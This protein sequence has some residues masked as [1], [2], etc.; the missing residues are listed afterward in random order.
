MSRVKKT[1][2]IVGGVAA[3][4]VFFTGAK[5]GL[6]LK[7][8][9]DAVGIP[10]YCY[11]ETRNARMGQVFTK[12]QCDMIF[13]ARLDEF[14]EGIERCAPSIKQA[15]PKR[16]VAHLSLAYNIGTGAYCK[17]S[18][19]RLQNAGH[20]IAA[21]DMFLKWNR[22]G[23]MVLRGLTRRRIEERDWCRSGA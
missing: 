14:G 23:G 9:R 13:I 15:P 7:T 4:A 18:V 3:L 8:Y 20:D 10:T 12:P 6:E 16:Y 5:E 2:G 17:S 1:A 21:C 19:A 22:A 11:G